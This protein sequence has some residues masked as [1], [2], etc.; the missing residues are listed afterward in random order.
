MSLRFRPSEYS[1]ET[2]TT[3]SNANPSTS[4]LTVSIDRLKPAYLEPP[5]PAP[6]VRTRLPG[7]T[8]QTAEVTVSPP[9][10]HRY[11]PSS[12]TLRLL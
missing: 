2:P 3:S 12:K 9:S 5:T 7:S 4:F 8:T 10:P 6:T 1:E 11:N